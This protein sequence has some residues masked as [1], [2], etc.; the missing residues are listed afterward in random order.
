MLDT[1]RQFSKRELVLF[2]LVFAVAGG[3]LLDRGRLRKSI[4]DLRLQIEI[5]KTREL[6]REGETEA[7]LKGDDILK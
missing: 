6:L 5:M 1:L 2:A 7:A 4:S 3:W